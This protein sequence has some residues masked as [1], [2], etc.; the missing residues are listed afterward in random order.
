MKWN[1]F[2][3][4]KPRQGELILLKID[5]FIYCTTAYLTKINKQFAYKSIYDKENILEYAKTN[6]MWCYLSDVNSEKV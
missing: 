5:G 2:H 6:D 4:K 1:I 3:K